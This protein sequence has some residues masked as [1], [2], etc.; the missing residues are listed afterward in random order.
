MNSTVRCPYCGMEGIRDSYGYECSKCKSYLT[1]FTEAGP[2]VW[3]EYFELPSN[4][5]SPVVGPP[6]VSVDIIK[7]GINEVIKVG[8]SHE[9]T[10][11]RD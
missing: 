2:D 9:V 5:L 4:F 10:P 8:E 1:R 3:I 7:Y 6:I 11:G